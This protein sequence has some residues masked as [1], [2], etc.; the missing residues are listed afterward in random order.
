[1]LRFDDTQRIEPHCSGFPHVA[2]NTFLGAACTTIA[3]GTDSSFFVVLNVAIHFVDLVI[4][5]F[6]IINS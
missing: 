4:L 1:M 6:F 2:V 3:L 5:L